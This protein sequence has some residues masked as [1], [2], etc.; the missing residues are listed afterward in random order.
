MG[1]PRIDLLEGVIDGTNTV[2]TIPQAYQPGTARYFLNG[3]L[4]YAPDDDGIVET[5]PSSGEISVKEAPL[6]GDRHQLLYE[7]ITSPGPSFNPFLSFTVELHLTTPSG[8]ECEVLDFVTVPRDLQIEAD[9]NAPPALP[10]GI[11]VEETPPPPSVP[12][13]VS[14]E[15]LDFVSVPKAFVV[16]QI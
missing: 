14:F 8:M 4:K 13:G 12:S 11:M 9:V 7:D 3:Q 5:D 6:D 2:F 1:H 16:N 15:D 10:F